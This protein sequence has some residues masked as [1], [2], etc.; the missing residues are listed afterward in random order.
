VL[1]WLLL[2]LTPVVVAALGHQ[3]AKG[4]D[5]GNTLQPYFRAVKHR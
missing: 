1:P 2:S 3:M 5:E 4:G